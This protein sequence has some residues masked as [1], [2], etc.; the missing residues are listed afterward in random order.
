MNIEQYEYVLVLMQTVF[1]SLFN[2]YPQHYALKKLDSIVD[3][4]WA[5][6]AEIV[7]KM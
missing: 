4:F 3:E 1:M 5:E 2:F 7:N 6:V